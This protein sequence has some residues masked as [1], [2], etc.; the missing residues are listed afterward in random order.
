MGEEII[1]SAK[2]R[3]KS[4]EKKI[5]ESTIWWRKREI[6]LDWQADNYSKLDKDYQKV[7]AYNDKFRFF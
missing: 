5:R 4:I 2:A 3:R 7:N 1:M 6:F